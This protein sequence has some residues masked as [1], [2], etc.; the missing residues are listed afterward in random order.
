MNST[1]IDTADTLDASPDLAAADAH[2]QH[3]V[4]EERAAEAVLAEAK[5]A[6]MRAQAQTSEARDLARLADLDALCDGD[7]V[8]RALAP[9]RKAAEDH[10]AGAVTA[11]HALEAKR[12]EYERLAA[13]AARIRA[14]R[15]VGTPAPRIASASTVTGTVGRELA[16]ALRSAG[17]SPQAARETLVDL[18]RLCS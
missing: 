4:A 18:V 14:L 6:R 9:L 13:E 10:L 3:T 11:A 8:H 17:V 1:T 16:D 7:A 2:Y 15:G 12:R 5:A